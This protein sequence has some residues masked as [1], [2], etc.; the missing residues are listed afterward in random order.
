MLKFLGGIYQNAVNGTGGNMYNFV[1]QA[2][3]IKGLH[4]CITKSQNVLIPPQFVSWT[5]EELIS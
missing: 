2:R 4:I 5:T 1:F 3:A